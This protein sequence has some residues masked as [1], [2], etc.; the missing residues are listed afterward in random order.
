MAPEHD[1]QEEEREGVGNRPPQAPPAEQL[2]EENR[3]H[4]PAQMDEGE[5]QSDRETSRERASTSMESPTLKTKST[6]GITVGG[7]EKTPSDSSRG[8]LPLESSAASD[9]L[10]ESPHDT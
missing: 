6:E 10:A 9:G 5:I 1:R 3:A 4:S 2:E 8:E 7:T